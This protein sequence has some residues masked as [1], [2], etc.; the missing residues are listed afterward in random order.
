MLTYQLAL[1]WREPIITAIIINLVTR[2]FD[3]VQDLW[4]WKW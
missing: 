3:A 4:I 2:D 1:F